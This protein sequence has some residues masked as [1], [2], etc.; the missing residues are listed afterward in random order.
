MTR[1][2]N[3]ALAKGGPPKPSGGS[4]H[5]HGYYSRGGGTQAGQLQ[6]RCGTRMFEN[7]FSGLEPA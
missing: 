2:R 6:Q 3:Q 5:G 4:G 1:P 7:L